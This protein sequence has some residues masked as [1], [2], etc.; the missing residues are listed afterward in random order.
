M[1][2]LKKFYKFVSG[3]FLLIFIESINVESLLKNSASYV[4]VNSEQWTSALCCYDESIFIMNLEAGP[5]ETHGRALEILSD[6]IK[7]SIIAGARQSKG[8]DPLGI[9]HEIM[10]ARPSLYCFKT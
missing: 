4:S 3:L 7:S 9:D 6:C 5:P 8:G 10:R 2:K 1:C